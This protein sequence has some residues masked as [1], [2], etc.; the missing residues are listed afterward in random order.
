LER[1]LGLMVSDAK[2]VNQWFTEHQRELIV[3]RGVLM[4]GLAYYFQ[5]LAF[6]INIQR[7][8][9]ILNGGQTLSLHVAK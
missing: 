3:L 2:P 4:P 1:A 9:I 5:T 6:L 8:K 7:W